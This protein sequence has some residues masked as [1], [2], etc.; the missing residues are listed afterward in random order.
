[1]D[2]PTRPQLF[3]VGAR[4][5]LV[6]AESRPYGRR[7]TAEQVYLPGSDVNLIEGG[8]SI[9]AEEVMSQLGTG[10]KDLTLD[11]SSGAA[12]DRVAFERTCGEVLRHGAT[13]AYVTVQFTRTSTALGAV[14][15]ASG[16]VVQT[17]GGVRF[18]TQSD[19]NFGATSLGPVSVVAR[20]AEAGKAGNVQAG[21]VTSFVSTKA[22][23]T[24]LVTNP[25]FGSGGDESESDK[26]L[27]YRVRLWPKAT[28]RGTLE[29][30]EFGALTVAGIVQATAYEELSEPLGLPTGFISL[31]IA[32]QNGQ[33]N[34]AL[35]AAVVLALEAYR[36]GGVW[37]DTYGGTPYYQSVELDLSYSTGTD[38]VAAFD[39]VR[40]SVVAAINGLRPNETLELSLII[41]A[42]KRVSGVIVYDDS[43]VIPAGDIVPT[44]GQV[45][46]TKTSLVNPA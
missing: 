45:I 25:S 46:R 5:L 15:Q 37:V 26:R 22:D 31:Y 9:M 21:T 11:G 14:T 19:A 17:T 30:I 38:T 20:A 7:I 39:N 16:T 29:A 43:V 36:G 41:A 32:D 18:I 12:L 1:M 13:P 44:T 35:V 33:A 6:R 34:S 27:R 4:D 2:L 3:E 8:A 40:K 23:T 42:C 24:L 10:L 28:R